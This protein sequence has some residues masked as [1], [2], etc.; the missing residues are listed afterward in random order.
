M[1]SNKWNVTNIFYVNANL[2]D[3][4]ASRIKLFTLYD[5]TGAFSLCASFYESLELKNIQNDT[6][7]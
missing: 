5:V 2:Q 4:D 3:S 7:G 1:Y 6:L